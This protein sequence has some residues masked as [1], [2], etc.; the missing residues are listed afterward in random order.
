[1]QKKDFMA[2]Y[3]I[4]IEPTT[5]ASIIKFT[6]NTIAVRGSYEFNTIDEAK[7]SPL[8]QQLFYLPFVKKV[9]ITAN[10]IAIERYDIVTWKDVQNEVKEQIE[11]YLNNGGKLITQDITPK[12]LAIEVYAESTPNPSVMKFAC[13]T[14]L[15]KTPLEYKNIEDA[16]HAPLASALFKFPF[17]KEV[18]ISKNYVAVTT[19]KNVDWNEIIVPL[20]SFIRE[21]LA[22]GKEAILNEELLENLEKKEKKPTEITNLDPFSKQIIAII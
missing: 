13:N 9:F 6:C 4:D 15:S 10:F 8:A 1:L 3:S 16:K 20:R 11:Q 17:V 19:F 21:F 2:N 14:L 22:S 18:F 7:P 5:N 12:T